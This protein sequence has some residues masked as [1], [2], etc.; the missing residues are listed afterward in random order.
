MIAMQLS[1]DF[2]LLLAMTGAFLDYFQSPDTKTGHSAK[3][4][5]LGS[6]AT[7][8]TLCQVIDVP[9]FL[10]IS[11]TK[12]AGKMI[13]YCLISV[14]GILVSFA[15][16]A[17]IA[18]TVNYCAEFTV[19]W[20][21]NFCVFLAVEVLILHP[22][23]AMAVYIATKRTYER[24]RYRIKKEMENT[25]DLGNSGILS[26][27]GKKDCDEQAPLPNDIEPVFRFDNS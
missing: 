19:V 3:S 27:Y 6:G 7:A 21:M 10:M 16:G 11:Y 22:I 24:L 2:L 15:V 9:I 8:F 4:S 14:C 26:P 13:N 1:M 17:I 25:I 12:D 20:I 5:D 23:Y 18:M